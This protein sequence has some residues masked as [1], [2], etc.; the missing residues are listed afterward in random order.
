MVFELKKHVQKHR[1][2]LPTQFVLKID[3]I[4]NNIPIEVDVTMDVKDIHYS[5]VLFAS[6]WRYHV[7][8]LGYISVDNKKEL[9]DDVQ[10]MEYLSLN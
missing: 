6:Y 8:I 1:R 4:C 2:K 9:I 5:K 3:D 10:I 7:K